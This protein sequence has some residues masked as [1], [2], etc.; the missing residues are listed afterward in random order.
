[1]PTTTPT[2]EISTVGIVDPVLYSNSLFYVKY[3][4]P[5]TLL[6]PAIVADTTAISTITYFIEDP[7]FTTVTALPPVVYGNN[8]IATYPTLA[9]DA[10]LTVTYSV[11]L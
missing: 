11:V 10:R 4:H 1:M 7:T 2:I 3:S 6:V 8:L 5:V 9:T